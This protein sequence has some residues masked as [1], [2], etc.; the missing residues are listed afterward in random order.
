MK[1]SHEITHLFQSL[2]IQL[3]Q[4]EMEPSLELKDGAQ[5]KEELLSGA[6]GDVGVCHLCLENLCLLVFCWDHR[7]Q[8]FLRDG[9]MKA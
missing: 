7:L 9:E 1:V 6:Q 8:D 2:V 3:E 5:S 4:P